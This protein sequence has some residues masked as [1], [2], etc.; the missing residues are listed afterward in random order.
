MWWE[1]SPLTLSRLTDC[2]C[3]IRDLIQIK[4]SM[5]MRRT[6]LLRMSCQVRQESGGR[7]VNGLVVG[8][9]EVSESWQ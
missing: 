8:H 4:T 5:Q 3:T 2:D 6:R 1:L 7:E 9:T